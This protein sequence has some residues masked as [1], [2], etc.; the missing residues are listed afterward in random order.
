MGLDQYATAV[1]ENGN[2]E[3]IAYWRKHPNLQGWMERLW[4]EKEH[5]NANE[6][7]NNLS[8]ELTLDDLSEL[9]VAV[10]NQ[11]LPETT[12][13]FFGNNA[14]AYYKDEDLEFI[15]KAKQ[16]ISEGLSV[17]YRSSW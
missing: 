15:Q 16:A 8:V 5:P 7:F 12:G 17:R 1:D 13:F 4:V 11:E 10:R 3:E 14:D 9:E 2:V 6:E